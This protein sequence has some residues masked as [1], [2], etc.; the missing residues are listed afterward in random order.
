MTSEDEREIW[1]TGGVAAT[2]AS[3]GASLGATSFWDKESDE[4]NTHR[5]SILLTSRSLV[6]RTLVFPYFSGELEKQAKVVVTRSVS[7]LR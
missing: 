7:G 1:L 4:L 5:L 3:A 6:E 2:P